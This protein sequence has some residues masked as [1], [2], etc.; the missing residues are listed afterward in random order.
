VGIIYC[1]DNSP[2]AIDNDSEQE[3]DVNVILSVDTR[4]KS[5]SDIQNSIPEP[6]SCHECTNCNRKSDLTTRVCESDINMCYVNL[7]QNFILI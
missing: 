3:P 2:S 4:P 1:Q 5:S 7:F 6:F